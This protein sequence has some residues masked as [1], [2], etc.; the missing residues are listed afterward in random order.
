MMGTFIA[1]TDCASALH[2]LGDSTRLAVV[3][4]LMRGSRTVGQMQRMLGVEQSL[5]SHHLRVMRSARLLVADREG[6]TVRYRLA[7]ALLES[8]A[9]GVIDMGC[10]KLAFSEA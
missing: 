2:C 7:P 6:R 4:L 8:G 5:L 9:H 1:D 3:R 10:C